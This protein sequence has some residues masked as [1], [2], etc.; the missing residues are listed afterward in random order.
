VFFCFVGAALAANSCLSFL[1]VR[2]F[3][4]QAFGFALL[5]ELLFCIAR[6]HAL[7]PAGATRAKLLRA[8]LST[9]TEK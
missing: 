5:G 8:I 6:I 4:V 3:L 7:H 2:F 9:A 1:T